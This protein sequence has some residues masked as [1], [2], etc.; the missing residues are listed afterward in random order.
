MKLSLD[1]LLYIHRPL[2]L[3]GV[4]KGFDYFTHAYL[5]TLGFRKYSHNSVLYWVW[6]DNI[7]ESTPCGTPVV[8]IHGI[9]A[10]FLPYILFIRRIRFLP[11]QQRPPAIFLIELP[12]ISMQICSVVP[13]SHQTVDAIATALTRHGGWGQARFIGHSYGT[14]VVSWMI[15][16]KPQM[17]AGAIL[18]DPVCFLTFTPKTA[19]SFLYKQPTTAEEHIIHFF[20]SRELHIANVLTRHFWWWEN[21]LWVEDFG[22]IPVTAFLAGQDAIVPSLAVLRYLNKYRIPYHFYDKYLHAEFLVREK[23]MEDILETLN[24]NCRAVHPDNAHR[25]PHPYAAVH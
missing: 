9:G 25:L 4:I 5:Y 3:Y 7:K 8:L 24:H 2:A 17:V 23:P 22:N 6:Q 20:V 10:G 15:K 19:Y 21:C 13:S 18:I 16:Q 12:H 1:P 14:Y 11:K